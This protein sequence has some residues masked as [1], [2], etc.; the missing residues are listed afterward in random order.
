MCGRSADFVAAL[1][2]AADDGRASPAELLIMTVEANV[3]R[4]NK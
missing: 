3:V 4:N 1:A 2:S